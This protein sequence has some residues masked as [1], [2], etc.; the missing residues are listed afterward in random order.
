MVVYGQ[1]KGGGEQY[2][3]GSRAQG[4]PVTKGVLGFQVQYP[5]S[6]LEKRMVTLPRV[7][8]GFSASSLLRKT[9]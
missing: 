1:K 9:Q 6:N 5:E 8:A 4:Q 7:K 3:D 2:L